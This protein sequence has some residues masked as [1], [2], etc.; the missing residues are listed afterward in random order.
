MIQIAEEL[1]VKRPKSKLL[2]VFPGQGCQKFIN[3]TYLQDTIFWK[4][5]DDILG[6]KLSDII[7]EQGPG[8][9]S[10]RFAQPAIVAAC[11]QDL[12]RWPEKIISDL[13]KIDPFFDENEIGFLGNSL[14][15]IVAAHGA[16]YFDKKTALTLADLRGLVMQEVI[17]KVEEQDKS[18][19][20]M[21]I[22]INLDRTIIE[23]TC[24]DAREY[25]IVN[26]SNVNS[27]LDNYKQIAIAGNK[28]AVAIVTLELEERITNR[29]YPGISTD[30]KTVPEI[31]RFAD[32][33]GPFHT[34]CILPAEQELA[35]KVSDYEIFDNA[36]VSSGRRHVLFQTY[37]RGIVN[38]GNAAIYNI[39]RQMTKTIELCQTLRYASKE[40][41]KYIVEL[42]PGKSI[43]SIMKNRGGFTIVDYKKAA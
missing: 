31:K 2:L 28:P 7:K 42:G 30:E 37:A 17:P 8:L 10:T 32:A 19:P 21:T 41:Y 18:V 1:V 16:G 11:I 5:V 40:D 9:N 27:N 15:E 39:I 23:Q 35:K 26:L 6:Y 36:K 24:A 3:G 29:E 20:F 34:E 33:P 13:K 12:Q 25:G 14:G 4:D 22:T 38:N 43:S